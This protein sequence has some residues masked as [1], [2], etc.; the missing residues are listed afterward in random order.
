M[1][2]PSPICQTQT[3]EENGVLTS[4]KCMSQFSNDE[5]KISLTANA[6]N[7]QNPT[8]PSLPFPIQPY[9]TQIHETQRHKF[10]LL[11]PLSASH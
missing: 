6:K 3:G 9:E 7:P 2:R 5:C 8:V 10:P 4:A 1:S 11:D